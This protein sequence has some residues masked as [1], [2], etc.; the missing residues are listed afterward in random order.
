M[1]KKEKN[2]EK[3]TD[4]N[5]CKWLRISIIVSSIAT[6]ILSV[7]NLFFNVNIIFAIITCIITFILNKTRDKIILKNKKK[8]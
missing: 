1:K 5:K 3:I 2:K 8:E 7:A 4:Y 6:I